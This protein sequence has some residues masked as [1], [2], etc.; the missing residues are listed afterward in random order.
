VD[1]HPET[2][3]FER[4]TADQVVAMNI[5]RFRIAAGIT[6]GELGEL[7][8]W[9]ATN[10][11]AA[12]RSADPAR[13]RRR[14]DAQALTEIAAAL[15]VPLVALFLPPPGDGDAARYLLATRSGD[16]DMAAYMEALVMPDSDSD[17]PAMEA[18]RDAINA[19]SRRYLTP[20]W[21]DRVAAWL[22]AGMSPQER[23][24]EV[25]ILRDRRRELLDTAAVL[26][27]IADQVEAGK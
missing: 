7:L 9:T 6:Q 10:V 19:A 1:K 26:E 14:F 16:S 12:E 15:G 23:A 11:S 4:V 2:P 5:R 22:S 8:G 21:A 20:D 27:R 25:Q 24:D 17:G 13:D 18:Y 3:P